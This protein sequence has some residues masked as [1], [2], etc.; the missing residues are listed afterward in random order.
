M[1][2]YDPSTWTPDYVEE[3]E[4]DCSDVLLSTLSVAKKLLANEDYDG[5]ACGFMN[6]TLGL[7]LLARFWPDYYLPPLYANHFALSKIFAFGLH[8][9]SNAQASLQRACDCAEKLDSLKANRDLLVMKKIL[10]AFQSGRSLSKIEAEYGQD[11][12]DDI[13]SMG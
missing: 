5:A 13:L 6:V 11:F 1:D 10:K 9:A 7:T 12:P 8:D 3:N 2:K 4:S